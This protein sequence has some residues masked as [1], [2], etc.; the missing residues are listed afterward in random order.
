MKIAILNTK[1]GASKSTTA[2][3]AASAYFL[4]RGEEVTLYELDD[5]NRD[6]EIFSESAIKTAQIQVA[7]GEFLSP[8][9]TKILAKK[10]T[11]AVIDVGGNRTTTITITALAKSRMSI[12]I[13]LFIIPMSGGSQD[14]L[15]AI[16]T[17]DLIRDFNRPIIFCLSRARRELKDPRVKYQF[18]HFFAKYPK[19]KA[20]FLRDSDAIDLSRDMK[21]SVYEIAQD[22]T[23]KTAFEEQIQQAFLA[24]DE[25]SIF[26]AQQTLDIIDDSILFYNECL[27][28]A[29][30]LLDRYNP[31]NQNK[32]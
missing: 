18:K 20:F 15:N 29:F 12:A 8:E 31:K 1:G 32:E 30:K 22:S 17:F 23:I 14:F 9:L 21:K 28:P 13:D 11:N 3:Q 10:E 27:I 25:M 24:D 5:E 4:A 19:E 7:D 16:K 26:A 2:F 6:S